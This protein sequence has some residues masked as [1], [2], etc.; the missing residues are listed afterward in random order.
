MQRSPH[1][2]Y[3]PTT[4]F[5]F[6]LHFAGRF[7][8]WYALMLALEVSAATSSILMPYTIGQMVKIVTQ[9]ASNIPAVWSVLAVP[10]AAFVALNLGE[11][12]FS[13]LAGSCRIYVAPRI[14]ITVTKDVFAYLQYHSHRFINNNF[15][16]A[17]A[18]KI[19]EMSHG[20]SMALSVAIFDF[21]P[22]LVKLAVSSALLSFVSGELALFVLV[23][24]VIFLSVSFRLAR[25]AQFYARLHSTA[26]SETTG[27]LVDSVTNLSSVR[28]FSRLGF[29]QDYINGFLNIEIKTGTRSMGYMEKIQWFQFSGAMLLK[30]GIVFIGVLLWRD[31][32]IDVAAF[33]MGIS[34]ALLIISE[35]RNLGRRLLEFFE[36]IGNIANGV[37]AIVRPHEIIDAPNAPALKIAK[38]EIEFRD[39]SFGYTPDRNVFEHLNLTIK[40]GQRVGL[41]GFS[42]SGKSSLLN[43]VLRLYD[44]QQGAI[45]IDGVDIRDVTQDSLH[46]QISL[47]PQDPG[48]FHRSLAENIRYGRL[49][50]DDAEI[51]EAA[52][53]A[54]VHEFISEMPESYASLVGERGVKLSGGQRQRIAIAR[55]FAKAAPILIMDEATSSL[56][57]LTEQAIQDSLNVIMKGRTVI[58]VAHRLSTIAHLDR[59]LV[60]DRGRIVEDGSH[61]EL[62]ARGGAYARLWNRQVD[63]FIG[64]DG[65]AAE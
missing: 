18:H 47:I 12:V 35:V 24:S 57:S 62:I 43:L 44:P 48:L 46:S 40:P 53:S 8:G 5:R 25:K 41:V 58:V 30:I 19:S 21:L 29:E 2:P 59:I 50:A 27:K 33:V 60:F 23:W 54:H 49:E 11:V 28:L 13:R 9:A 42:G 56:D 10:F 1:A 45:L 38:G 63:G 31:G 7:R 55:V 52:K 15:A 26:R 39:L 51:I 22:I 20:V 65:I 64:G 4:P 17:L 3:L 14:R 32:H 36:F 34:L 6:A 16:G 37:H 61:H